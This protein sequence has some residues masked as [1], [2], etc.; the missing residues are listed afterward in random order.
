MCSV[1]LADGAIAHV[2]AVRGVAKALMVEDEPRSGQPGGDET[3]LVMGKKQ[4]NDLAERVWTRI[5]EQRP[6]WEAHFGIGTGGDLEVAIPAPPRSRAGQ[7]VLSSSGGSDL[8]V[9]FRPEH[10]CYAVSDADQML[11]VA[12]QLLSDHALFVVINQ[13]GRWASTT[14]VGPGEDLPLKAGQSAEIVSWS[15]VRDRVVSR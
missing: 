4:L 5:R 13:S 2:R 9:R 1:R 8:S 12:E 15:G 10:M 7:L 3:E 11:A 14:I 6:E